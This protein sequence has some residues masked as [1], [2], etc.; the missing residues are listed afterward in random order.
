MAHPN[1]EL[2]RQGFEAFAKGDMDTLRELFDPGIIYHA[3]G[4]S[5][6][7]GVYHGPDEVIG[8][9]ARL[10]EQSGGTFQADVHDILANDRHTVVLFRASAERDGASLADRQ[11]LVAHLRAGKIAEVWVI[12]EDSYAFDAFFA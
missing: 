5:P 10:F 1:E 6:L 2:L 12:S 7:A 3:P 11:V 8:L 9:F 4:R